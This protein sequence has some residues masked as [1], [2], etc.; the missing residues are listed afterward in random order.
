MKKLI[1]SFVILTAAACLLA[2]PASAADKPMTNVSLISGPFGTS[3]YVLSSALEEMSKKF[4]PS[5]RITSS[6]T[7][8]LVFNCK[9]MNKEPELKKSMFMSY[10]VGIN[11]L[12]Q[13][14][15]K[16][17]DKKYPSA[18][19]IA[20]YNIGSVWLASLDAKIK[21]KED[22]VG[23]KVAIG[24]GTQILWAIEPEW[25]IRIGWELKDKM[26][27]QYVGTDPAK[28][29]LLDGLVNAAVV[30]GYADPVSGKFSA[31]PQTIELIATGKKLSHIPWGKEAV[32]KVIAQGIPIA[33]L[34][35]PANSLPGQDNALDVFADPIAWVA[36]PEFPEEL[37]YEITKMIIANVSQFKNYHNLG[38]LMS[39][40]SLP[41]GW[42]PKNIHPGA[43]RAYREAKILD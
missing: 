40:K 2:A 41:F 35:L 27:I 34:N 1:Y 36:W 30:G 32:Q 19:L 9:K 20:N 4:H 18:M 37:A 16:P 28:T 38:E 13:Q 3:S 22:L 11:W 42:D 29:A 6:E 8:G 33:H 14:G 12:A 26:D 15:L 5:I 10:T 23:K 7:P 17:F 21:G 31:S 25:L 39:P 43:L 24:R